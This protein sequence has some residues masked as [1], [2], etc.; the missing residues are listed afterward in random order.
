M[1]SV[2]EK[3]CRK[4]KEQIMVA[5]CNLMAI[6][7][8]RR[9]DCNASQDAINPFSE[10]HAK[11]VRGGSEWKIYCRPIITRKRGIYIVYAFP[12]KKISEEKISNK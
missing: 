8:V 1:T 9:S 6:K 2:M 10:D 5:K 11:R 4:K 3:K 12:K 7:E